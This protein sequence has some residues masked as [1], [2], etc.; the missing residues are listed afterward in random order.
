MFVP[1]SGDSDQLEV[2][3]KMLDEVLNDERRRAE[4][5]LGKEDTG[6]RGRE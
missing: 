4:K 1:S 6:L 3:R 2:M 5:E